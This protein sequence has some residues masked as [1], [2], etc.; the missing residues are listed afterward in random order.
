MSRSGIDKEISAII[1][2]E[3]SAQP[4]R[5]LNTLFLTSNTTNN[6]S[7]M[8][9]RGQTRIELQPRSMNRRKTESS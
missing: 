6:F 2:E 5:D 8:N 7:Q 3:R 4:E 9:H 1:E